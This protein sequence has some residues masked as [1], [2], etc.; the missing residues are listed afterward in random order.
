MWSILHLHEYVVWQY[1]SGTCLRKDQYA[2]I[3]L[4]RASCVA[5]NG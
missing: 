4:I 3:L 5:I 2:V 1:N